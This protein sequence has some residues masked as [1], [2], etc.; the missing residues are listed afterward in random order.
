MVLS[1][2]IEEERQTLG[3][4]MSLGFNDKEI[5]Y[6]FFFYSLILCLIGGFLGS[7]FGVLGGIQ[8]V[9]NMFSSDFRPIP[10]VGNLSNSTIIV[11]ICYVLFITIVI[12]CTS[13]ISSRKILTI[14]PLESIR[15]NLNLQPGNMVLIEKIF[16]KFNFH[17]PPLTRFS[18]RSVFHKKRKAIFGIIGIAIATTVALFGSFMYIGYGENLNYHYTENEK[19]DVQVFI[20]P[21]FNFNTS[22]ISM[23]L[24]TNGLNDEIKKSEPFICTPIR[25]KSDM[26]RI[27]NLIG[28]QE[29]STM[30]NFNG[31]SNPSSDS[32]YITVDVAKRINA[33]K[34]DFVT[35]ISQNNEPENLKISHIL[36]EMSGNG[37]FTSIST[38]RS[39][40][41][42]NN[43]SYINGLYLKTN[44]PDKVE[45]ALVYNSSI[46]KII[47]KKDLIAMA[48]NNQNQ[49]ITAFGLSFLIGLITG[50]AISV[51]II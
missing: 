26:S 44:N 2:L 32:L 30:R 7:L 35:I 14:T 17:L 49:Q 43:G 5:I 16:N 8:I 25:F 19:W 27:Y 12:A 11:G 34:N 45:Q 24:N 42:N 48:V 33:N 1:H 13:I 21:N 37:I 20:D 38:A 46:Q 15:P 31:I 39:I 40:I 4:L 29:N 10:T 41:R 50:L 6:Y 28:I 47:L 9:S 36:K 51:I 22:N 18:L 23:I 3:V